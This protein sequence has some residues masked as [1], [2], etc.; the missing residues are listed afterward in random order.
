VT[1]PVSLL[2]NAAG[3]ILATVLIGWALLGRPVRTDGHNR[4]AKRPIY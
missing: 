4:G 2:W 3:F 1:A